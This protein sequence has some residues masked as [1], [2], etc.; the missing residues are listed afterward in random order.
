MSE[1]D[2][3]LTGYL[4]RAAR[5]LVETSATTTGQYA[6]LTR[7]Q[8]RD[9]ERGRI[10]LTDKQ[11]HDLQHALEQLGAVFIHDGENPGLGEGAGVRLKFTVEKVRRIEAWEDEG[12]PAYDDDV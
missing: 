6:G 1:H 4:A 3:H 12:G 8:V 2:F 11:L 5:A 7:A 9:Y 10:V